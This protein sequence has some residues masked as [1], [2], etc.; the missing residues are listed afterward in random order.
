MASQW[1]RLTSSSFSYSSM[2]SGSC[3]ASAHSSSS[4]VAYRSL[5]KLRFSGFRHA[6]KATHVRAGDSDLS[7][8]FTLRRFFHS[9][10]CTSNAALTT[11]SVFMSASMSLQW[12]MMPATVVRPL[13]SEHE[14]WLRSAPT[15]RLCSS[16]TSRAR[17]TGTGCSWPNGASASSC[18][19]LRSVSSS[20]FTQA[21]MVMSGWN[22]PSG[23]ISMYSHRRRSNSGSFSVGSVT[24]TAASC[25]P[26]RSSR[27]EQL[28]T[29][30]NRLTWPT[31]RPLPR[32]SSPS[33]VNSRQGTP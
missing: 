16:V 21:S 30:L 8:A 7:M 20:R 28:S 3:G 1:A 17:Y 15:A 31:L 33:M 12:N 27:S 5:T 23:S 11:L 29:A 32:A 14:K 9:S 24:P 26:K 18:A 19:T 2:A 10:I 4:R 22:A 13:E 25:P 6:S